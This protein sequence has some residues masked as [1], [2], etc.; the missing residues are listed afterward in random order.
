MATRTDYT[1]I[2]FRDIQEKIPDQVDIETIIG[3]Y[4]YTLPTKII[5]NVYEIQ[6][7][8]S[9]CYMAFVTDNGL[10]LYDVHDHWVKFADY[11]NKWT[12]EKITWSLTTE[13]DY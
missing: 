12:K 7:C 13:E 6:C 9:T 1:K 8:G 5:D 11:T 4:K 3:Y 2:R 10:F